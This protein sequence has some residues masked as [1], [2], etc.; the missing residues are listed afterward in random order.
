MC[1]LSFNIFQVIIYDIIISTNKNGISISAFETR[2]KLVYRFYDAYV[3]RS[4]L[5]PLG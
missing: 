1:K 3:Y 2:Q 5:C 4:N